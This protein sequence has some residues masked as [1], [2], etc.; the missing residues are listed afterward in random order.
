MRSFDIKVKFRD[1]DDAGI[2]LND[3]FSEEIIK[4]LRAKMIIL[5]GN[6]TGISV[7]KKIE[8]LIKKMDYVIRVEEVY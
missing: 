1:T 3:V 4:F 5:L 2:T 6:D 7:N 8:E